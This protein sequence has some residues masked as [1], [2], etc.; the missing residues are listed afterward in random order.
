MGCAVCV[1]LFGVKLCSVGQQLKLELGVGGG[2]RDHPVS[3][4]K[5][6][7]DGCSEPRHTAADD[8][9]LRDPK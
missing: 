4:T 9:C 1:P 5:D 3:S 2:G 8:G 7:R 6:P